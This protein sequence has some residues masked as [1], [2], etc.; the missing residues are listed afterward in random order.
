M[1]YGFYCTIMKEQAVRW[2]TR[3]GEDGYINV[4]KYKPNEKLKVLIFKEMTEQFF[5][6]WLNLNIQRIR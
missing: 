1:Y 2:A 3:F 6:N 4:Y 5:G